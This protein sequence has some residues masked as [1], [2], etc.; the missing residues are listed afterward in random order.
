MLT[1][2]VGYA[3]TLKL[4]GRMKRSAMPSPRFL[5]IHSSNVEGVW[6]GVVDLSSVALTSPLTAVS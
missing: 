6:P 5:K 4:Y 1:S 2:V 3:H